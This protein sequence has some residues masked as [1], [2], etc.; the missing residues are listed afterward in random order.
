MLQRHAV[1]HC[2]GQQLL[3]LG[4][5]ALKLTHPSGLGCVDTAIL[6]QPRCGARSAI[7]ETAGASFGTPIIRFPVNLLRFIVVPS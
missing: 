5:L 1:Q 3:E 4:V 2:V 6:G 7:S